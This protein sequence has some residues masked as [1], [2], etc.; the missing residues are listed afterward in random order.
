MIREEIKFDAIF[1]DPHFCHTNILKYC[2][3]PFD[4]IEHM[5]DSFIQNYNARVDPG[6]HTLWLG[7]AF[8]ANFEAAKSIMDRL[9]GTKEMVRGNHDRLSISQYLRMGFE[10]VHSR[11]VYST[12]GDVPVIYSHY[13]SVVWA[14]K[15]RHVN[16]YPPSGTEDIVIH[17]HT[18]SLDKIRG[19][20]IHAGVDAWGYG[21]ATRDEISELVKEILCHTLAHSTE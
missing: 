13:P 9:H 8:F 15:S 4:S 1:S 14:Y 2:E 11:F 21:P 10:R 3:R 16:R 18:H 19:R 12:F 17:G 7:D 5:N 20:E 6:D